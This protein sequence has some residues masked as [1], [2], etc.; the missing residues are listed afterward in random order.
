MRIKS[1]IL[2]VA[3]LAVLTA[4]GKKPSS[5]P[6]SQLPKGEVAIEVP[7]SGMEFASSTEYLRATSSASSNNRE[8]ASQKAMTQARAN[9]AAA[10]N[11][12]TQ[13]VTDNFLSSYG[14]G[15]KDDVRSRYLSLTREVTS[16]ILSGVRVICQKV[17]MTTDTGKYNSYV[18]IELAG[19]ELCKKIGDKISSDSKLRTDFE[20]QKFQETFE[21]EMSKIEQ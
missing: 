18:A 3:S 16:Q 15:D 4:C 7:C 9:L 14:E 8:L 6:Q 17:T 10:I 11:V 19:D 21:K 12:K 1:F 2:A 5:T 20:Y 13:T